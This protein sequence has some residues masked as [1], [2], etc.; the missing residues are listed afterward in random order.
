MVEGHKVIRT[1]RIL[2]DLSSRAIMAAC[3]DTHENI[4]ATK[5]MFLEGS[6]GQQEGHD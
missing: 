1:V 6:R 2:P 5:E 4:V 3:R